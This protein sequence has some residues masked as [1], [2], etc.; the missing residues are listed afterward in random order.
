MIS[1]R[2]LTVVVILTA[3][4]SLD[5]LADDGWSRTCPPRRLLNPDQM[6]CRLKGTWK[7]TMVLEVDCNQFGHAYLRYENVDTGEFH[8]IGRYCRGWGNA[9]EL[10]GNPSPVGP[11]PFSG[12]VWDLDA[13]REPEY[14]ARKFYAISTV[15]TDPFVL[16]GINGGWGHGGLVNNCNTHVRDAWH[17][18]T[19]E[20]YDLCPVWHTSNHLLSQIAKRHPE[21]RGG[22]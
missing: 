11:S 13:A 22:R 15:K 16:R 10:I 14:Q 1:R 12:V 9:R 5:C 17:C 21:I 20:W 8:T 7:I 19:G 2:W 6:P 4:P 3:F 18:Y